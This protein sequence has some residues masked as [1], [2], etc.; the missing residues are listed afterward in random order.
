MEVAT[1][2][3]VRQNV[4]KWRRRQK[5][6]KHRHQLSRPEHPK[7]D[8]RARVNCDIN[9]SC[10]K[11][12]ITM[13]KWDKNSTRRKGNKEANKEDVDNKKMQNMKA[14]MIMMMIIMTTTITTITMITEVMVMAAAAVVGGGGGGGG[15]D[16]GHDKCFFHIK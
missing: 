2:L 3:V 1:G 6:A 11:K 9:E 13:I 7:S 10:V 14:M 5:T 15:N 4:R 12:N 16:D 8:S